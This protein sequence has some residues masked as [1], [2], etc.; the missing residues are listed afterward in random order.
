MK[1]IKKLVDMIDEEL[2]SAKEYAE[3]YIEFKSK[4]DISW[5]NKFKEMSNDELIHAMNIH[6]LAT[7]E[8]E[9]LNKVFIAP[10]EME[11]EWEHS[12]KEYIEKAAWIKQM[13]MM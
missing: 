6:D 5:A 7:K 10:V 4:N 11:E 13:L 2:C 3:K 8:I 12:H 1:K 9:E